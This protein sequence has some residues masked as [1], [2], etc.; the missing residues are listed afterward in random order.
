MRCLVNYPTVSPDDTTN[1]GGLSHLLANLDVL[2][3][4]GFKC[5]VIARLS[6]PII[7]FSGSVCWLS[8]VPGRANPRADTTAMAGAPPRP[9]PFETLL[10]GVRRVALAAVSSLAVRII[11]PQLIIERANGRFHLK[12][13]APV[14]RAVHLVE[15]NDEF[16][17]DGRYDGALTAIEYRGLPFPQL[18]APWPVQ[19]VGTFDFALLSARFDALQ[20]AGT[21]IDV[22]LL[23]TGGIKA[24]DEVMPF[25]EGH[26]WLVDRPI[27][28]HV[29]GNAQEAHDHRILLHGHVRTDQIDASCFHC[30]LV[31]YSE[32]TYSDARLALGSPTK[33][34][35]YIDYSLP[36]ITN[37]DL[38]RQRY[39]GNIDCRMLESMDKNDVMCWAN[40]MTTLRSMASVTGYSNSFLSFI[41]DLGLTVC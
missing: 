22:L 32:S 10:N 35:N 37:R 2:G 23:G 19:S 3:R 15:I 25:L 36:I 16:I 14:R 28:L 5:V 18:A 41:K 7:S 13:T 4:L 33:I 30:A 26:P 27:R 34:F 40:H 8:I 12:R 9:R 17:P 24:L 20:Q 38:I 21:A 31:F 1:S 29:M 39:L 11:K 6:W